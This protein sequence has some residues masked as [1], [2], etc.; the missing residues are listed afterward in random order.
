[1]A[2]WPWAETAVKAVGRTMLPTGARSTGSR[3]LPGAYE[4]V[5]PSP[6]PLGERRARGGSRGGDRAGR[7]R[8]GEA[9]ESRRHAPPDARRAAHSGDF[10]AAASPISPAAGQ[11][12]P[13]PRSSPTPG[14]PDPPHPPDSPGPRARPQAAAAA[15]AARRQRARATLESFAFPT[16]C[17]GAPGAES[18]A[19]V[20][21]TSST[22]AARS[23]WLASATTPRSHDRSR[24]GVP[25]GLDAAEPHE[26]AA[27]RRRAPVGRL[28]G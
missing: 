5:R 27:L 10:A 17:R 19:C 13:P 11:D 24:P 2:R 7:P 15:A 18:S 22:A 6:H 25:P 4:T 16:P 12:R 23:A 26:R 3:P 21:T 1:V 28:G 14:S 8:L 20:P 9:R